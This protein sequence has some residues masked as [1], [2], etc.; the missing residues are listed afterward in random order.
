MKR[1]DQEFISKYSKSQDFEKVISSLNMALVSKEELF[2][3]DEAKENYTNIHILGVPRSGTTLINQYLASGL[4]VGYINNLIAAFWK[5]PL[6]GVHLSKKLLGTNFCSSFDS[7]FGKTLAIK[8]PHEFGYFWS[9]ILGFDDLKA[10]TSEQKRNQNLV[11]LSNQL[12]NIS[13]AFDKPVIYKSIFLGWSASRVA[14]LMPKSLFIY[15]KRN[16]MDNALSLLKIRDKYFQNHETWASFKP[17]EY[18]ELKSMTPIEQVVGQ[19]YYLNRS[20]EKEMSKIKAANKI[21]INYED[22]TKRPKDLTEL[23]IY[24]ARCL[25]GK[26]NQDETEVPAYFDLKKQQIDSELKGKLTNAYLKFKDN[27]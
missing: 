19:V 15:V 2:S 12:N 5:A 3:Q 23:I 9:D 27:E 4:D 7:A 10:P 25:G 17:A 22:F 8:E 20:F 26:V 14:E 21:T 6:H 16:W 13:N 1:K 18:Q 11:H 24:K